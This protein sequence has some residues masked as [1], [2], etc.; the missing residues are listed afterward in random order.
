MQV[1]V[2]FYWGGGVGGRKSFIPLFRWNLDLSRGLWHSNADFFLSNCWWVKHVKDEASHVCTVYV[3]VCETSRL[4]L[5]FIVFL[6]HS[7]CRLKK[8]LSRPMR[9][10]SIS[11]ER[12][13]ESQL[14]LQR[15]MKNNCSEMVNEVGR[16][17]TKVSSGL[18]GVFWWWCF[19]FWK[20]WVIPSLYYFSCCWFFFLCC[21]LEATAF[22]W[23][24][25]YCYSS[26]CR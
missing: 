7:L 25:F 12:E 8:L 2:Q 22:S 16:L 1:A 17:R 20:N 9:K 3:R 15:E 14:S 11:E 24:S 4:F 23:C 18:F 21:I 6:T 10:P 26:R 5:C 19:F 13:M